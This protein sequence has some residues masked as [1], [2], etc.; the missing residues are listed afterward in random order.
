MCV[1]P[2]PHSGAGKT[3]LVDLLAGRVS[4]RGSYTMNGEDVTPAHVRDR[5]AYVQQEDMFFPYLTVREHLWFQSQLRLPT[6]LPDHQKQGVCACVFVC[7][8]VCPVCVLCVCPVCVC[9]TV[10]PFTRACVCRC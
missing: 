5:C 7:V 6:T 1:C 3:T 9:G 2:S 4:Y 8:R 10:A